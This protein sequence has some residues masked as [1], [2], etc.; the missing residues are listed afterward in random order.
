[1][2]LQALATP[3][4]VS[5]LPALSINFSPHDRELLNYAVLAS[6]LD[7]FDPMEKALYEAIKVQ[8]L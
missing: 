8:E 4:K 5:K 2:S 6:K 3:N 1:M 7:P